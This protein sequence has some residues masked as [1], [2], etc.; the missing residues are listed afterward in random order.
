MS[1]EEKEKRTDTYP[2]AKPRGVPVVKDADA[3]RSGG[4]KYNH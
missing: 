2:L 4:P 1:E 3:S